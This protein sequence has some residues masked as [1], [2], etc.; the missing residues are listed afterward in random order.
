[1]RTASRMVLMVIVAASLSLLAAGCNS[2]EKSE[3]PAMGTTDSKS[4]HPKS[5]H[6]KSDHPKSDHPSSEHP[7]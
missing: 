7:K 1:M 5:D 3:T 6:P 4:D 2:S